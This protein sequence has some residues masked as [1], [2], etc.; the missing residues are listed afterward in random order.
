MAKRK[1]ILNMVKTLSPIEFA[2]TPQNPNDGEGFSFGVFDKVEDGCAIINPIFTA[3][4]FCSVEFTKKALK[5][6]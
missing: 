6:G 3:I 5:Y 1:K 2:V 4:F